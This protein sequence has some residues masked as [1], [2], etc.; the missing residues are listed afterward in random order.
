MPILEDVKAKLE[1][2][3]TRVKARIA[4]VKT[5]IEERRGGSSSSNPKLKIR[6]EIKEKG[7]IPAIRG[8]IETRRAERL[9]AGKR[10]SE[11][12]VETEEEL[13]FQRGPIAIEG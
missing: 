3:R 5:K 1:E 10:T 7:L 9:A 12:E 2:K 4:E 6:A 8:R 13:K 11:V